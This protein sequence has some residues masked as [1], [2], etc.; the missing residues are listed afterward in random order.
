MAE[1]TLLSEIQSPEL[2]NYNTRQIIDEIIDRIQRHPEWKELW[3]GEL[4]QS[5]LYVIINIFAYLFSKNAEVANRLIK[6]N[7][8]LLAK[9]PN[10]IVALMSNYGLKIRSTTHSIA[11]IQATRTDGGNLVND[12][13]LSGNPGSPFALSAE[14]NT[15]GNV[16]FEIYEKD[17]NG[18]IDYFKPIILRKGLVNNLFGYSGETSLESIDIDSQ[19]KKEK[20]FYTLSNSP[21]IEDSI[22]VYYIFDEQKIELI[23]TD[24]FTVPA[25]GDTDRFPGG[26]PYYKIIYNEAGTATI[27]F[28]TQYFGG[29]FPK[30][31]VGQLQ[32]FY[33]FGGGLNTNVPNGSINF[34]TNVSNIPITFSNNGDSG[35]G[36]DVEDLNLAKFYA[37]MR[38]GR[39]K[40]IVD[41]RDALLSLT[42]MSV[43]HKVISPKY[44]LLPNKDS[45]PILHYYNY[46]VPRRNFTQFSLPTPSTDDTVSTYEYKMRAS[47]NEFLN[48]SK[49]HDGVVADEVI[50]AE[51]TENNI[52]YALRYKPILSGTLTVSAYDHYNV[53][54]DRLIYSSSYF[55]ETNLNDVNTSTAKLKSYTRVIETVFNL[56]DR[57]EFHFEMD[58]Y[59][60]EITI[61]NQINGVNIQYNTPNIL[62]QQVN[63]Q[64]IQT[65]KNSW[66]TDEPLLLIPA[67]QNYITLNYNYFYYDNGYF[68]LNSPTIG[69]N[70]K[71]KIFVDSTDT[72][73]KNFLSLIKFIGSNSDIRFT[74]AIPESRKIFLDNSNFNY[75]NN[76]LDIKLNLDDIDRNLIL[77]DLISWPNRNSNIGPT[78]AYE[79]RD[80][81]LKNIFLK[82]NTNLI[83]EIYDEYDVLKDRIIYENVSFGQTTPGIRT[84]R[85]KDN[86]L[87]QGQQEIFKDPVIDI[88][89][90][91]YSLTYFDY[92]DS[93]IYF[94][95]ADSDDEQVSF[96]YSFPRQP[97]VNNLLENSISDAWAQYDDG[98]EASL[99]VDGFGKKFNFI[100]NNF[101]LFPS[102]D[103]LTVVNAIPTGWQYYYDTFNQIDT[104]LEEQED[105]DP[106]NWYYDT[107]SYEQKT[108]VPRVDGNGD[109]VLDGNG[110]QIIDE[111]WL[112]FATTIY[113]KSLYDQIVIDNENYR[114]IVI[115]TLIKPIIQVPTEIITVLPSPVP[116]DGV[117]N[118]NTVTNKLSLIKD[119]VIENNAQN[120]KYLFEKKSENALG[121]G[122]SYSFQIDEA[123][124]NSQLIFKFEYSIFSNDE[125][126]SEFIDGDVI[127]YIIA[128][129]EAKTVVFQ[130]T[131]INSVENSF[132]VV[133]NSINFINYR[134]IFHIPNNKNNKYKIYIDN[135]QIY[136]EPIDTTYF[137][138]ILSDGL[139][140]LILYKPQTNI[141]QQIVR[142][143][144]VA[145]DLGLNANSIANFNMEY[146]VSDGIYNNIIGV[147]VIGMKIVNDAY[148][149]ALIDLNDNYD[150]SATL[151]SKMIDIL[152][153]NQNNNKIS[154]NFNTSDYTRFR[155]V[156]HTKTN[157]SQSFQI[158]FT[159]IQIGM[160]PADIYNEKFYFKV[161]YGREKFNSIR[162]NY[163]PHPY[164][165]EDESM[166]F[167]DILRNQNKRIIGIEPILKKINFNPMGISLFLTFTNT[168]KSEEVLN[169]VQALIIDNFS[170]NNT[171][172]SIKIG[173]IFSLDLISQKLIQNFVNLG[174]VGA[175]VTDV[176]SLL[177]ENP[178]SDD[179]FF[180]APPILYENLL[181][182]ETEYPN[183]LGIADKYDI[184][185]T[186]L[187]L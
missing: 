8:I 162:C 43:K 157:Q 144:G 94:A 100:S 183:I 81:N 165:Q 3:N 120:P 164:F 59:L 182:L 45:V 30:N 58:G 77:N 91:V 49:I 150:S 111:V 51:Y 130:D 39:G 88:A 106:A 140:N 170:Y 36:I 104:V 70:S 53:E 135:I 177:A 22:R 176:N 20:F 134:L 44:S 166:G 6:E 121:C 13:L 89:T 124:T 116:V 123:N 50:S 38:V 12:L 180:I 131:T 16:I 145:F 72:N 125:Y 69:A 143:Q 151:T 132:E 64:I 78:L 172:E 26:Q 21:V 18:K 87:I 92:A 107:I 179:Y 108:L 178:T 146:S 142:G 63:Q 25:V 98:I 115:G 71:L 99:P 5:A 67:G 32:I 83:M 163:E 1:L 24:S 129:N 17:E 33:R 37:P 122:V 147:S 68:Y 185:V 47:L 102:P 28:G 181:A 186:Y 9:D 82:Q 152:F 158:S 118:Q 34:S 136:Q 154:F 62:A 169:N 41:E 27:V 76:S 85:D 148:T 112:P 126:L 48:L 119:I 52:Q 84:D 141:T 175:K 40:Q 42:G 113:L 173:E 55:G 2:I 23:E 159:N 105:P 19:D 149:Y 79:L 7:F 138:E 155:L 4:R 14:G 54:I 127:T 29:S 167:L 31:E 139:D 35:G 57:N 171:N 10:N 117:G 65:I 133:F 11:N 56:N 74:Y 128:E 114:N 137:L 101:I 109:P 75:V 168:S 184:K 46:I 97:F 160:K 95:L 110:E 156:F 61:P 187:K 93:K 86:N 66:T 96:P 90:G 103:P 161:Y 15:G 153:D 174:L 73:R 80:E 60:L